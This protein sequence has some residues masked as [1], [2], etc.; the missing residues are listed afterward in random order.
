MKKIVFLLAV[1]L[2]GNTAIAQNSKVNRALNYA[3]PEY[4]Q[5]DKA[6]EAIEEAI[7]HEKTKDS[8]KAWKARAIVYQS[9]AQTKD[10][11][12]K[13]LSENPLQEAIKSYEKAIE[14]DVKKRYWKDIKPQMQMCGIL[15]INKGIEY[16][17][18][19]DFKKALAAFETSLKIDKIT[20]PGKVDSMII[21]NSGIAADRAK[22]YEKAIKY[23]TKTC[24]MDYEGS[25]VYGYLANVYKAK[26]DTVQYIKTL[27][28]GIE[29]HPESVPIIFELINY[30]LDSDQSEN[31]LAYIDKAI[32][33][34][35]EN[36]TLYF[37]KGAIYDKQNNMEEAKAAYEASVKRKPDYFDAYYNLGALFFNKGVEML[38]QANTLPASKQK[39]YEIALREAYKELEK[40]LPYLEKAHEVNPEETTT[41][42]TLKE[43]YFK[44][45]NDKPEYMEKYKIYNEKVKNIK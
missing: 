32:Q 25:K 41:I 15:S 9:I 38:N 28:T 23:Y 8:P 1:A 43:I 22:N 27:E 7:V 37:A 34:D 6:K 24:Q 33:K 30:Y 21:Y 44:I 12:F 36:H 26:G 40:A 29:K 4:N 20:E 14:L 31:A 3:K 5:L 19:E 10:E 13:K 16:F 11:K 39:E 17:N 45:R 42:T 18:A 35:P 2:V